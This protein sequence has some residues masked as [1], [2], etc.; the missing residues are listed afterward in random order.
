MNARRH[1]M[2]R[3]SRNTYARS[4]AQHYL[5]QLTANIHYHTGL[6]ALY[7]KPHSPDVSPA[8]LLP[9]P[10]RLH[11][12]YRRRLQY[13]QQHITARLFDKSSMLDNA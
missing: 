7:R 11:R 12:R 9:S 4:L 6:A 5:V 8:T 2:L 1:S 10:T 13:R 3:A